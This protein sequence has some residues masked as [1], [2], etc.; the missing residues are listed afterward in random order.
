MN[1]Q[2]LP[3]HRNATESGGV[4]ARGT[5]LAFDFGEKRLGVAVGELELELAHPLVTIAAATDEE[6]LAAVEELVKEWS[7]VLFVV[8]L[9]THPDGNAH[10]LATR[11]GRFAER[12][13]GRF[14]RPARLVDERL[15][16]AT[17]SMALAEAGVRGRRQKEMLD[18]VAAQHILQ[19][20]FASRASTC[21]PP[22]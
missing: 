17:A 4:P 22:R 5:V 10:A 11:C 15:T 13:R 14:G 18:Q 3:G 8:G 12:L 6:R 2:P 20:Y 16:S 9:P 21:D 1:A 7:P 19:A